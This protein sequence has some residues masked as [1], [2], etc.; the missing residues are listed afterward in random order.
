MQNTG[1]K[2]MADNIAGIEMNNIDAFDAG[3]NANGIRQSRGLI[4]GQ[5]NL[6]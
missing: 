3:K 4:L 6:R 5:I 1:Y 2:F